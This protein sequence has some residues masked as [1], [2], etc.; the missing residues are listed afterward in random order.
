V[1]ES[2]FV[3]AAKADRQLPWSS[4][5]RATR[6]PLTVDPANPSYTPPGRFRYRL[7]IP[8]AI[9]WCTSRMPMY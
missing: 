7:P 5:G 3:F 2:D 9:R 4:Q 6:L 8:T 1:E